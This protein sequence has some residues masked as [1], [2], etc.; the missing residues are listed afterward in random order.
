MQKEKFP[1]PI[2]RGKTKI[3]TLED[4]LADLG[5]AVRANPHRVGSKP[6]KQGLVKSYDSQGSQHTRAITQRMLG[7]GDV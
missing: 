6:P 1:D 7:E 3:R 4:A 2:Y 5:A